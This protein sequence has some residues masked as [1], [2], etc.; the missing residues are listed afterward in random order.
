[1]IVPTPS[2]PIIDPDLPIVD[3]HHHLWF[4]PDRTL[5][6]M[7][8]HDSIAA[9]ALA[10]TLRRHRRYLLDEFVSDLG[11]GHRVCASVF[12]E[13]HT[14]YRASGPETL[15]SV[16]EVE[17]VNGIAAMAASGAFGEARV[18][19]G[20][21]GNVDLRLGDAV[22]DILRKHLQAGGGRYRGVRSGDVAYDE[23]WRILGAGVG[24]PHLLSEPGFRAGFK[25]LH[26]LGLSFD[27]LLL[28]PQLPELIELAR[29]FPETQIILNHVGAPVG[30]GRY[31]GQ[32]KERFPIWREHIRTLC[33]CENVAV[34]LGGLGI[35]FGGFESY[36]STP[37][38]TS[39]QL[40]Q[41]WKPYIETCI[42]AFGTHRCMFES[43]FPVDAAAGSYPVLWNAFKRLAAGASWEEKIELF[44]GTATRVYRL[45]PVSG[46]KANGNDDFRRR[47]DI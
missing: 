13:A 36:L 25:W 17:F 16:G 45:E 24:V 26:Q 8:T 6:A 14:M 20:I 21:V 23:D 44:S 27:A 33:R 28:E 9:G 7:E 22:E 35:P 46:V 2:E 42:E 10:P 15:K 11:A 34:K 38:P 4:L 3:A 31:A 40:A 41:E 43:N 30:V 5:A 37:P 1:M 18:C 29:S 32:R 39:W 47:Q 19:A 12:V